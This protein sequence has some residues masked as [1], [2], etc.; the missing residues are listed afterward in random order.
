MVASAARQGG[1]GGGHASSIAPISPSS[2]PP[3][4]PASPR[5]DRPHVN[6]RLSRRGLPAARH[7]PGVTSHSGAAARL[8]SAIGQT[9]PLPARYSILQAYSVQPLQH[10]TS[11]RGHHSI[12]A[13][14]R[15]TGGATARPTAVP[16]APRVVLN[17]N[18]DAYRRR[19]Y[20][21]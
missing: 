18:A 17:G 20:Q 15:A 13:P 9:A 12:G 19:R 8:S 16:V 21:R 5:L 6:E 3:V 7:E 11:A 14:S 1:G 4:S 10:G 2:P